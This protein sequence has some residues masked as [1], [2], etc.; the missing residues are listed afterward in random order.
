MTLRVLFT[1][2]PLLS[3]GFMAWGTMLRLALV[4]RKTRDWVLLGA[5]C[6]LAVGWVAL[7][8]ADPTPDTSG[9][10]GNVGA[11]GT[12]ATGLATCV[13]FL[14]A[15]IRHY[16]AKAAGALAGQGQGQGHWYPAQA[17]APTPASPYAPPR[18]SAGYGYPPVGAQTV[19]QNPSAVS[20][21]A[22]TPVPGPAPAAE[23]TPPPTP[24]PQP[25]IGQVRAELDELS[26]L[27]RNQ[28]PH[29]QQNPN[30][31]NPNQGNPYQDKG[32]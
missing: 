14:V 6:V 28:T 21:H 20:A 26:E 18:Q 27:L 10:Q 22:P 11:F 30:Q 2:L 13:Y 32:Q 8:G 16:E 9:W 23:P 15:D 12:I 31:G 3:C 5:S 17:Q 29:P 19:P 25:R 24:V 4:T 7:I 1:L